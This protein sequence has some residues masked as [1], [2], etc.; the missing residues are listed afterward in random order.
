MNSTVD[1]KVAPLFWAVVVL[2]IGIFVSLFRIII[3]NQG[4]MVYTLDDAYIHLSLAEN[5]A[6]FHYGI[7]MQDFSAPSSSILW[8]FILA[9]F[10]LLPYMQWVPLI[11]NSIIALLTLFVSW[12]ILELIFIDQE[13]KFRQRLVT[14]FLIVLI[15]ATN[16]IGLIFTGMEHSLQVLLVGAITYGLLYEFRNKILLWWMAPVFVITSLV[17]YEDLAI[18]SVILIILFLQGYRRQTIIVA[19]VIGVFVGG[20]SLFLVHLGLHPLPL[21]VLYKLSHYSDSMNPLVRISNMMHTA[22]GMVLVMC[23]VIFSF[24]GMNPHRVAAERLLSFA[25]AI[26]LLFHLAYGYT[27]W[28]WYCRYEIYVWFFSLV[29]L[30]YLLRENI[31]LAFTSSSLMFFSITLFGLLLVCSRYIQILETIPLASSNIFEQHYQMHRFATEYYRKPVGVNDIGYV[32]FQND[33]YVLDYG[34]LASE[35]AYRERNS[36]G[37]INWMDS[38]ASANGVELAMIYDN[39]FPQRP[40]TWTKVADMQLRHDQFVIGDPV[41][42]FY[43]M[44]ENSYHEVRDE[45]IDFEKTLPYRNMLVIYNKTFL[46][47]SF[48]N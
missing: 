15:P 17:R 4:V 32:S 7:N 21:S 9:P 18:V 30:T 47:N 29:A 42:S 41:V 44:K 34:G 39:W 3:M 20:F 13:E 16:L 23:V 24:L 38:L 19:T 43:V 6:H 45:L 25:A 35:P 10:T 26:A 46:N 22:G 37:D 48:R 1:Q 5:I 11:L 40:A 12:K 31:A 28:A 14:F 27:G 8:P 2:F 36:N 33:Q